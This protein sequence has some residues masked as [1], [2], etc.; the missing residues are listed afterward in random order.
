LIHHRDLIEILVRVASQGTRIGAAPRNG[1]LRSSAGY[2]FAGDPRPVT[3]E[4][5]GR[6]IAEGLGRSHPLMF[7]FAEPLLWLAAAGN[8]L[9]AQ[10]RGRPNT[11][12]TDKIREA[13]AGDWASSPHALQH[14]LNFTPACSLAE[15][16]RETAH[17][18][19][20]HGWL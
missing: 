17:W 6:L 18:Y 16:F 20:D 12:N 13:T 8:E 7:Y 1:S 10:W 2:Y 3:Y 9:A 5:L 4:Q 14:E 19:L 15:R 11:F